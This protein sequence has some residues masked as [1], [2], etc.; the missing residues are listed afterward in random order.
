MIARV[1]I[2]GDHDEE[3]YPGA[4]KNSYNIKPKGDINL[5]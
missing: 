1:N 4:V 2:K 5:P 3:I